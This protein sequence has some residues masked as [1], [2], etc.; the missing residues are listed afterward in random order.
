MPQRIHHT[1]K[2]EGRPSADQG[3]ACQSAWDSDG[4]AVW[5]GLVD[6]GC[7]GWV[8]MVILMLVVVVV[9]AAG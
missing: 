7:L 8:V 1:D 5:T 3:R 4:V 2:N 6:W 9:V